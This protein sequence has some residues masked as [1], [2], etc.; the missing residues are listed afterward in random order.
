MREMEGQ[1]ER[2]SKHKYIDDETLK[3]NLGW[4][5]TRLGSWWQSHYLSKM[6]NNHN[7]GVIH[8]RSTRS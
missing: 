4:L 1:L 7:D 5:T 3:C 2:K 8:K 6:P